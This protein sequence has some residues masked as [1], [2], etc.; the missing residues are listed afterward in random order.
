[1]IELWAVRTELIRHGQDFGRRHE[2]KYIRLGEF[3]TSLILHSKPKYQF[4]DIPHRTCYVRNKQFL[5][6]AL[7]GPVAV[8]ALSL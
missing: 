4:V 7:T 1:M 2:N 3:K 5:K 6:L 8:R